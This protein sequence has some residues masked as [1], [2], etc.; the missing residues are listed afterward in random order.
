MGQSRPNERKVPIHYTKLVKSELKNRDR[1][2]AQDTDNLFFKVKKIQTK[3]VLDK[4]QI[5]LRKGRSKEVGPLNAGK[6]R[7][8]SQVNNIIFMN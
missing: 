8:A 3:S 2:A 6:L 4:V 5:A 1:R 7:D